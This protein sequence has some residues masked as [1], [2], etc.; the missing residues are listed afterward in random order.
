MKHNR[1]N[2]GEAQ[3]INDPAVRQLPELRSAEERLAEVEKKRKSAEQEGRRLRDDYEILDQKMKAL[4]ESFDRRKEELD[5]SFS[6]RKKEIEDD[7]SVR[8]K[9]LDEL[10]SGRKETI[11]CVDDEGNRLV[12]EIKSALYEVR[13]SV[14]KSSEGFGGLYAEVVDAAKERLESALSET[15]KVITSLVNLNDAISNKSVEYVEESV[16]RRREAEKKISEWRENKL[17]QVDDDIIK[18]RKENEDKKVAL[19][20]RNMELLLMKRSIES[21]KDA[22][23]AYIEK[24]VGETAGMIESNNMELRNQI[25]I[26]YAELKRVNKEKEEYQYKYRKS[27]ALVKTDLLDENRAI[28]EELEKI[29]AEMIQN[30]LHASVITRADQYEKLKSDLEVASRRRDEL[31]VEVAK[32]KSFEGLNTVLKEMVDKQADKI[33]EIKDMLDRLKD[34][35]KSREYR[36]RPITKRVFT[37][38]YTEFDNGNAVTELDW[39]DG[40]KNGIKSDGFEFSDRLIEA[41]HTCVKT[42]IW[43]PITVLAGVS[44]TGKSELPR[45][46]SQYG[47]LLFMNT[48][49][50]PDWDSPS[51]MLGYYNALERRFEAKPILRAMYQMQEE[52]GDFLKKLSL[53]LLD[54][55]NLAHIELYFSDM[56]SKLEENRNKRESEAASIDI[57]LGAGIDSLPIKLTRNMLWIGTMN[58]DETTKGLSDKVVDRSNII[59]FPRPKVLASREL[60]HNGS[61]AIR[62]LDRKIWVKWQREYLELCEKDGFHKAAEAYKKTIVRISEC[63]EKGGRALGHRVWQSIEYYVAA[64]PRVAEFGEKIDSDEAKKER[65]K[66]FA[67]AVAFK[68]M[69]KLR[70]IETEGKVRRDCLDAIKNIIDEKVPELSADYSNALAA[71]YGVFM[72]KSGE[73]LEDKKESVPDAEDSVPQDDGVKSKNAE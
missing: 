17:A 57:D 22:L 21:Q 24:K 62:L 8:K 34:G 56:L 64:C 70:G 37:G 47:G 25:D 6:D 58:E 18:A 38:K 4:K 10:I 63:L 19:D 9:E 66:A 14:R 55:M 60:K 72:W 16:N 7:I 2:P 44:G 35:E 23:E 27:E 49:V 5:K 40:I 3:P 42:A 13:E 41:F 52:N 61:N 59:V 51:S 1:N 33:E 69:P 30:E 32:F 53:F 36:M 67:E 11:K 48:P 65:D 71:P 46:Y 15:D 39:L 31:E 68:V 28:K 20:Q 29:R 73:F 12:S 26:L 50:K 45:L 54:E 43:S